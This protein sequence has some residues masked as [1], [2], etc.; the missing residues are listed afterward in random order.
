MA[1]S[2]KH[3]FPISLALVGLSFCLGIS[4]T[5]ET[6]SFQVEGQTRSSAIYVPTGIENPPVVFFIHGANGSGGAF[7][8][9]TKGDVTA[10][11]EKFIAVY[12]SASSNCP[13]MRSRRKS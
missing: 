13:A 11:R 6:L 12:P 8:N 3:L 7:E 9:E 1:F 2:K 10:D 4:Q 5:K